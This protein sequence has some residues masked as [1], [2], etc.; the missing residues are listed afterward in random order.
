MSSS[1]KENS[2]QLPWPEPFV[3]D[4]DDPDWP[5]FDNDAQVR[6]WVLTHRKVLL[7]TVTWNLCARTPPPKEAVLTNLLQKK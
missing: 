5:Q 6:R 1:R 7:R 2:P 4:F 3:E